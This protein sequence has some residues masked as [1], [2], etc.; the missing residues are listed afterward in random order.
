MRRVWG[1][2]AILLCCF[3]VVS[4]DRA[5]PDRKNQ[6]LLPFT[7]TIEGTRGEMPFAA[8]ISASATAR[9]ICYTA[10]EVLSGLTVTET[11]AGISIRQ[12]AFQAENQPDGSGFLTPLDLLLSPAALSAVE[13]NNGEKTLTYADGTKLILSADG[14]PRALIGIDLFYTVSNFS[15]GEK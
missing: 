3:S 10:P 5:K 12:G 14:T 7:A 9:A 6:I 11:S 13:E 2:V 15:P 8:E 4:C 1:L